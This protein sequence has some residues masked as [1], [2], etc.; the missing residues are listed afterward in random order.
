[1]SGIHHYIAAE[2]GD[3]AVVCNYASARGVVDAAALRRAEASD[4]IAKAAMTYG[5]KS[6]AYASARDAA[7]EEERTHKQ[8]IAA[9]AGVLGFR[10]GS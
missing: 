10:R 4:A 7:L 2:I 5:A 1:M 9:M 3:L 8:R 6:L